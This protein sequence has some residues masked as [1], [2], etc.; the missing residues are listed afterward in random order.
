MD[1]KNRYKLII[2]I[3]CLIILWSVWGCS[4]DSQKSLEDKIQ[5]AE[6]GLPSSTGILPWKTC[7]LYGQMDRYQIPGVSLAVIDDYKVDFAKGYGKQTGEKKLPL[8]TE[9]MFRAV[10]VSSQVSRFIA[11]NF[12]E[13]GILPLHEDV[14]HFLIGWKIPEN[15]WTRK[16]A[17]TLH[18][19]LKFNTAGLN[20]F[21]MVFY[22][23]GQEIPSLYQILEGLPPA[24]TPA[25]RVVSEPGKFKRSI[26]YW[27]VSYVVLEQLLKDV[28]GQPF[29]HIARDVLFLPWD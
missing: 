17:V 20:E 24:K 15:Q 22:P 9:S 7:S 27:V 1:N 11:L 2:G 4:Q 25:I 28:A 12:V 10:G 8:T 21:Y 29:P 13:R 14:N 6:N 19:L 18:S 26:N 16:Q 3:V 5:K 23:R